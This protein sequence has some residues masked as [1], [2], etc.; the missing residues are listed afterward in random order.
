LQAALASAAAFAAGA[1][2]PLL[3]AW[4]TPLPAVSLVIATSSLALLASLG[5]LAAHLGAASLARGSLRVTFWG[6]VAMLSTAL[7]GRLLGAAV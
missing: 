4:L 7:V 2:P 5:A 3:I 1:T 6:A